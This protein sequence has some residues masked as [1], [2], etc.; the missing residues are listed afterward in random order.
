MAGGD[1]LFPEGKK[2]LELHNLVHHL[3]H[4]VGK[5]ELVNV[6]GEVHY[7]AIHQDLTQSTKHEH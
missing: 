3:P 4:Q 6:H 7:K 1:N 2:N 5:V